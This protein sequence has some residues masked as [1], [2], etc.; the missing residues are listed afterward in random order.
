M[1][2]KKSTLALEELGRSLARLREAVEQPLENPLA[3]DGTIQRFEFTFELFWKAFKRLLEEE[4]LE[5]AT[6]REALRAAFKA[7][8]IRDEEA[9]LAMLADRNRTSHT[10]K[11]QLAEEIYEH[12]KGYL[13]E[14]ESVYRRL[15]PRSSDPRE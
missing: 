10:Y 4:G 7:Y 13:P 9:W 1:S 2:E 14:L 11:R 3:V 8:W 12:I 6:P 15:L 5:P